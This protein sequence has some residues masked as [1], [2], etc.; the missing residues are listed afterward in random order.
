[1]SEDSNETAVESASALLNADAFYESEPS[2]PTE[3]GASPEVE[4]E[5][6]DADAEEEST[7]AETET[8][9]EA[10][11]TLYTF[12]EESGNYTFRATD[13]DVSANTDEL[14]ELAKKGVG[15]E[16]KM[17]VAGRNE[18]Q[19][20]K[21]HREALS[22]IKQRETELESLADG[23]SSLL[24]SEEQIDDDLRETDT[25]EY[26]RLKELKESRKAK[27]L[28]AKQKV[29]ERR[30]LERNALISHEFKQLKEVM[31]W[32]TEEKFEEE[33]MQIG[34]YCES[35]G[36]TGEDVKDIINHKVYQAFSDAA[37]YRE[38]L[39][40][41]E[42]VVKEVKS[43]PKSVKSKAPAKPNKDR[44]AVEVLYGS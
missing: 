36:M 1:M 26:I 38:L 17:R 21:E 39:N 34:K 5:E 32:D 2:E 25:A 15:F 12:D 42:K 23:L 35:I 6:T 33:R 18:Q 28:E 10:D 8:E 4:E 19:R 22:K 41:K 43:A 7:E 3:A 16:K 37:K 44:T 24:D 11:G 30:T 14:I 20:S 27:I 29:D 9:L 31:G 40:K 13:K